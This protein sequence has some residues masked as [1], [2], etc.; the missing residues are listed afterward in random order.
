MI[1]GPSRGELGWGPSLQDRLT[2][3]MLLTTYFTVRYFFDCCALQW[4]PPSEHGPSSRQAEAAIPIRREVHV[5]RGTM[6]C[7]TSTRSHANNGLI[8][9]PR[10]SSRSGL[11]LERCC[12]AE[13]GLKLPVCA[14]Q[15]LGPEENLQGWRVGRASCAVTKSPK[16]KARV[17]Q[18]FCCKN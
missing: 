10:K 17:R 3:A 4:R 6:T 15:S 11:L 1:N 18:A 9:A 12:S 16:F 7:S 13:V 2:A 14:S 8:P 5:R